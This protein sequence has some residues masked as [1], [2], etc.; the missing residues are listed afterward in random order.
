MKYGAIKVLNLA[1]RGAEFT[2]GSKLKANL[3]Y[4]KNHPKRDSYPEG[5]K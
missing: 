2:R 3:E 1:L 5:K 4:F